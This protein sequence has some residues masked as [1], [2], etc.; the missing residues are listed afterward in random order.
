MGK[1]KAGKGRSCSGGAGG[2]GGDY[3][4]HNI[5]HNFDDFVLMNP[6]LLLNPFSF[7]AG[8][9]GACSSRKQAL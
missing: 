7:A 6:F 5:C 8:M 3:Y 1:R 4:D 9:E 2:G